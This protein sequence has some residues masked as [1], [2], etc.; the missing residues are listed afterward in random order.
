MNELTELAQYNRWTDKEI[1]LLKD[2]YKQPI[3]LVKLTM[4][5]P[6]RNDVDCRYKA[7]K[8]GIS[9]HKNNYHFYK[10]NFNLSD[11]EK[12]Y[13][14]GIFDGEGSLSKYYN[15]NNKSYYW[16]LSIGMTDKKVL[17]LFNDK[18]G[19]SLY[20]E[21]RE[22]NQK[23]IYRYQLV[24][25]NIIYFFLQGLIPYLIVKKEKTKQFFTDIETKYKIL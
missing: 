17:Q 15:K 3:K 4:L 16:R 18:L 5:F 13:M 1:Q 25:Q 10:I 8:L 9:G 11:I 20:I 2:W 23:T 6:N 14:A 22:I 19:G 21:K 24:K 7:Y 12:G